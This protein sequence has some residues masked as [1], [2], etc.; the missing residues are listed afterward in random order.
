MSSEKFYEIFYKTFE[1]VKEIEYKEQK[2]LK[3]L[4]NQ[5]AIILRNAIEST[6]ENIIKNVIDQ[7]WKSIQE[8]DAYNLKKGAILTRKN[9]T[10]YNI[11]RN[12]EF[13]YTILENK[14]NIYYEDW[15]GYVFCDYKSDYMEKNEFKNIIS[16]KL[17]IKEEEIEKYWKYC[18]KIENKEGDVLDIQKLHRNIILAYNEVSEI[19]ENKDDIVISTIHKAKG[20]E[21]ENVYIDKSTEIQQN[22]EDIVN[23]A[24]L[25]YVAITRAKEYC[26]KVE[27]EKG[28]NKLYYRKLNGEERQI[29]YYYK[30]RNK[31]KG[32]TKK[33]I[34]KI[35]IGLENDI[36]KTSFINDKIVGDA[37]QNIEYIEHMVKKGDY[38]DLIL[39]GEDYYIYHNQRKIGKMIISDLYALAQKSLNKVSQMTYKP[40]KYKKVRVKR[41]LTIA[42]FQEFIPSE[43]QNIYAKTGIWIGIELEG[44]GNLDW[45]K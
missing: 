44:F 20:K 16:S 31:G 10:V 8:T 32:H 3:Q 41:K 6:D 7:V 22:D 11:G 2:R 17:N 1:N 35:E 27:F 5:K 42:M 19:T 25:L 40:P 39:E 26:Y 14:N 45:N 37:T 23:Y 4:V 12:L 18:K 15:L 34:G 38:V 30:F 28:Q 13:Q 21:F 43:I 33:G 24:K 36:E 29:E 9:G